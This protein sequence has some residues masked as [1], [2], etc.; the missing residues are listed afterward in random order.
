MTAPARF[1]PTQAPWVGLPWG[2]VGGD[3]CSGFVN[4]PSGLFTWDVH[5]TVHDVGTRDAAPPLPFLHKAS[6]SKNFNY[7]DTVLQRTVFAARVVLAPLQ[8]ISS[9]YLTSVRLSGVIACAPVSPRWVWHKLI[10]FLTTSCQIMLCPY[11]SAEAALC[12]TDEQGQQVWVRR[13]MPTPD[14]M[15]VLKSKH[16]PPPTP[17]SPSLSHTQVLQHA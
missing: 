2:R 7:A 3:G 15:H 9:T 11:V 17:F 10:V 6:V 16:P 8:V 4:C 12:V 14:A 13:L 1:P 5:K